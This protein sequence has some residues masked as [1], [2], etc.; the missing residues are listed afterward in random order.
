MLKGKAAPAVVF[1]VRPA[2]SAAA[3]QRMRD[4]RSLTHG[5]GDGEGDDSAAAGGCWKELGLA[6]GEEEHIAA[7]LGRR[8]VL[9]SSGARGGGW[10]GRGMPFRR[11][12]VNYRGSLLGRTPG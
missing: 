7:R 10:R 1:R 4:I 3:L 5:L 6:A 8:A 12:G 2:A 9:R 11:T